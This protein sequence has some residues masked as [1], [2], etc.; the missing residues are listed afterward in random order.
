MP[1]ANPD[2][3]GTVVRF[4]LDNF[5]AAAV[6]LLDLT[7]VDASLVRFKGCFVAG[8]YTYIVPTD[9]TSS[10]GKLVRFDLN[11]FSARLE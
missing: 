8:G 1:N 6:A 3:F 7:Q 5:T 10:H 9:G 4:P 2:P 11:D